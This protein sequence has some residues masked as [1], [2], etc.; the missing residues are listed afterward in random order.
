MF[1]FFRPLFRLSGNLLLNAAEIDSKSKHANTDH[2][3]HGGICKLACE[4]RDKRLTAY[5]FNFLLKSMI[6]L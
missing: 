5:I 6:K 3:Y 2:G 4:F 1:R